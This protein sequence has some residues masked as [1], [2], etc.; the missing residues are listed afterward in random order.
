MEKKMEEHENNVTYGL[1]KTV[2]IFAGGILLIA[3]N[4]LYIIRIVEGDIS[5]FTTAGKNLYFLTPF[6]DI[7]LV[8]LFIMKLKLRTFEIATFEP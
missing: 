6:V 5:S 3:G 1:I 2:L 7:L 4:F 8:V